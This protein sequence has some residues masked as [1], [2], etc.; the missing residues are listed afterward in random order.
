VPDARETGRSA[1]TTLLAYVLEDASFREALVADGAAAADRWGIELTA[2]QRRGLQR[3]V[4]A[5]RRGPAPGADDT[6]RAPA[7]RPAPPV[8]PPGPSDGA[9]TD[10]TDG[11]AGSVAFVV[12]PF[13]EVRWPA[14]GVSLLQAAL[15][16]AGAPSDVVY[17][18]LDWADIVGR[19]LYDRVGVSSPTTSLAGEW[20]FAHLALGRDE[21]GGDTGRDRVDDVLRL[22]RAAAYLEDVLLGAHGDH[23]RFGLLFRMGEMRARARRYVTDLAALPAWGRYTVA[24]LTTTFQQNA[25]SLAL[26]AALRSHHPDLVIAFGGANCEGPMGRALLRN[27]P[28]VDLVFQGEAEEVFPAWVRRIATGGGRAALPPEREVITC[29]PVERLDAS[30]VPDYD[31]FYARLAAT[32]GEGAATALRQRTALP[33]ETSRGCWWGERSHCTF[34]GLNGRTMSFR[35]KTP[36]RALDE[37]RHL[38]GRHGTPGGPT[39]VLV[40]D[41]ILDYHYLGSFL[42]AL[43][44]DDLDVTLHYEVKANLRRDQLETLAAA[45][46]THL[47]P[48]IESLSNG[49][50]RLMRKGTTRL[51]N[52]QLLKWCRE[53][54]IH[55]SWNLLLGFPGESDEDYRDVPALCGRLTHLVPPEHVGAARADRFSPFFETPGELGIAGLRHE[56]AY[57]HVYAGLPVADRADIAYHFRIEAEA[58]MAGPETAASVHA[59]VDAWRAAHRRSASLVARWDGDHLVVT[60][61]RGDSDGHPG[62]D[63]GPSVVRL[64]LDDVESATLLAIDQAQVSAAVVRA[65]H[66]SHPGADVGRVLDALVERSL[67]LRDG[68]GYLALPVLDRPSLPSAQLRDATPPPRRRRIPLTVTR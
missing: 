14:L 58:P 13:A 23:F 17:A 29:P 9:A 27:F 30:P 31:D 1:L 37:L 43:A 67:A 52:V 60:D 57:D 55:P 63:A 56:P 54:G 44:A 62:A 32:P 7:A 61:T 40:V 8:G 66:A 36:E 10:A 65:V 48:G 3:N 22:G 46:V 47:Q 41:N 19:D 42:P 24:A 35:S 59:A 12:M 64:D 68:D 4:D 25:A 50:L 39:H 5:L 38:V 15:R 16:K 6:G 20:V 26:A 11:A 21:D 51:R 33:F 2:A 53:V 18:N 49:P 34:C 45:G 28:A